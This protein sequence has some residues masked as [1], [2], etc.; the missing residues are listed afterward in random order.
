ML[1]MLWPIKLKTP[2]FGLGTSFDEGLAVLRRLGDVEEVTD[3]ADGHSARVNTSHYAVALYEQH[4]RV[5]AVWYDDPS[6]RW[7]AIGKRR[8][9]RLYFRRY[10][11]SGQWKL[12]INNGWM[13][14][15][16]NDAVQATIVYGIHN[17]VI[18]ING[19]HDCEQFQAP[20]SEPAAP[21]TKGADDVQ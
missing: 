11:E 10:A 18:R 16:F 5:S 1:R 20:V 8:K 15:F 6:G 13:L 2:H 3:V 19:R 7:T 12:R 21:H 9:L 17:D 14:F 4:G